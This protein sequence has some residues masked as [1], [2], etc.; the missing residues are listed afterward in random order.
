[1]GFQR[2]ADLLVSMLKSESWRSFKD[3]LGSYSF[4]PGEFDY[5]LTQRG[6]RRKDVSELPDMD[7]KARLDEA[8]DERLTGKADYRRS[9]A[10]VRAE[11]PSVPGRPIEPFGFT[12]SESKALVDGTRDGVAGVQ[13]REALGARVRRL[14]NTGGETARNPAERLPQS[15]RLRRSAVRLGDSDLAALIMRSSRSSA[16]A[17][18]AQTSSRCGDQVPRL[19]A[20]TEAPSRLANACRH[21]ST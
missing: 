16:A 19:V 1:M 15:E 8:M 13:H 14:R 3:G 4:L 18:S 7:A 21:F 11:N 9:I 12:E 10:Q 17:G 6:I 20:L 5:F 2:M